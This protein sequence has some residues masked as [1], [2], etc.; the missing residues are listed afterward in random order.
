MVS[1]DPFWPPVH[2][3]RPAGREAFPLFRP[4][5]RTALAIALVLWLCMLSQAGAGATDAESIAR[6]EQPN[7]VRITG[8]MGEQ[9]HEP[10]AQA[11]AVL[12]GDGGQLVSVANLFTNRATR[13][14][15]ERYLV[16][17][18]DGRERQAKAV[19]VDAMLNLMVL[20]IVEPGAYPVAK[21]ASAAVR[22]GDEVIAI[23]GGNPGA[24]GFAVGRIKAQQ[25]RTTYGAG[26]GDMY[27]DSEIRLPDHAF[28][29]PLLDA[30][31]GV[32][33]I[34]TPNIHR[35]DTQPAT[36]GE[37]H[38][39]PAGG[40]RAFLRI[41]KA[42]PIAGQRWVGLAFRPLHSDD[43]AAAARLLGHSAG[44]RIDYVW[45]DG[46]AAKSDIRSGDILVSLNGEFLGHLHELERIM[47]G[48]RPGDEAE[49]ALL[50]GNK[51]AF[52]RIPVQS[53]P[54]WAGFV[55]WRV[56][57]SADGLPP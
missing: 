54:S 12:L 11:S 16:R 52:R 24:A 57:L 20:E 33:G 36:P 53:R 34:N 26:L 46:P 45:A 37:A 30:Q 40:A 27:I 22:P 49:L 18:A 3:Q 13:H 29:G 5:L 21:V 43:A 10:Y 7:V 14:V 39:I 9:G 1:V 19:S 38:A 15:C 6:R 44:L 50:R 56:P 35:P 8:F 42:S 48:L 25:K 31:G 2:R 55:P 32:V 51:L 23:A 4:P 41:A 17:L 47:R 28:G